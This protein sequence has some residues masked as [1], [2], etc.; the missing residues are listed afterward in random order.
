MPKNI[1]K[2]NKNFNKFQ[3]SAISIHTKNTKPKHTIR[4]LETGRNMSRC[5]QR[6]EERQTER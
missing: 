2:K 3:K 1:W 5:G 4:E 6:H